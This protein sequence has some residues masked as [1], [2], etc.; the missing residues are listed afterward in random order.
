MEAYG[1]QHNQVCRLFEEGGGLVDLLYHELFN[2][3]NQLKCGL[4]Q[5]LGVL[6]DQVHLCRIGGRKWSCSLERTEAMDGYGQQVD[7]GYIDKEKQQGT[8]YLVWYL[9]TMRSLHLQLGSI[10]VNMLEIRKIK[11]CEVHFLLV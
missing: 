9:R 4:I 6:V 1:G 5:C 10:F 11:P 8:Q 2:R 7:L 3:V